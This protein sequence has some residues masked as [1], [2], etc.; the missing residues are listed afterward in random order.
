MIY[1][2]ASIRVQPGCLSRFLEILKSNVPAVR[3]ETGCL[4]YRPTVDINAGLPPQLL[5]PDTVVIIEKW[6]SL[7]ALR[8]HLASPHMLAYREKV[9]ELVLSV[10]LKVLQ[11]A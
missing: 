2:I 9:K 6:D 10:S 1:V 8:N 4:D 3:A 5:E 11:E 7:E